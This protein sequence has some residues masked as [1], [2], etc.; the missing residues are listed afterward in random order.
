MFDVCIVGGGVSG[1]V[2]A[3]EFRKR[4]PKTTLAI[5]E[6]ESQPGG[7]LATQRF[8]GFRVPLGGSMIRGG[9]KRVIRLCQDLGLEILPVDKSSFLQSPDPEFNNG[10]IEKIK[11]E[12]RKFVS[13]T[14]EDISVENFLQR[15]LEKGEFERFVQNLLYRDFLQSSL[16]EFLDYYPPEDL[17]QPEGIREG[18]FY[19]KG[20]YGALIDRLVEGVRG[21]DQISMYLDTEVEETV[22]D[23]NKTWIVKT[24]RGNLQTSLVIWATDWSGVESLPDTPKNTIRE[25]IAPVPFLRAA[26]F[27]EKSKLTGGIVCGGELGKVFPLM[28]NVFQLA[29]TESIWARD[30]YEKIKDRSKEDVLELFQTLLER[31]VPESVRGDLRIDDVLVKYWKAGIHQFIRSPENETMLKIQKPQFGFYIIG[32]MVV[33]ENK[34]WTEGA[35]QSV[36]E[37]FDR[38]AFVMTS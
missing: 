22:L 29:Y 24:P 23:E 27:S 12:G 38:H 11:S 16:R 21:D 1:L 13:E 20:G 32:E 14:K 33:R 10:M 28:K 9:D 35:I 8:H 4:Y 15:I 36:E 25:Y 34:G 17:L 18:L 19:A 31:E 5:L 26:G 6:R 30:L 3:R 7:R 2:C 37:F